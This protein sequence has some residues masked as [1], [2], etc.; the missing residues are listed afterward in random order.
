MLTTN[1]IEVLKKI[2]KGICVRSTN[3]WWSKFPD[4]AHCSTIRKLIRLGLCNYQYGENGCCTGVKDLT[5]K[6][7]QALNILKESNK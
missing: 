6:G 1:D 7:K 3:H 4:M 5:D 2:D